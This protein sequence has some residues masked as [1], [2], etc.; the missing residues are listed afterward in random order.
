MTL[1]YLVWAS[2]LIDELAMCLQNK[3]AVERNDIMIKWYVVCFLKGVFS[4]SLEYGGRKWIFF[5]L[6]LCSDSAY[7]WHESNVWTC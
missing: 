7:I 5:F 3:F 1:A 4:I 6:E 2:N